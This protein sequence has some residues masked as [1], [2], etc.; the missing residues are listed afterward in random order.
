[1]TYLLDAIEDLPLIREK[2]LQLALDVNQFIYDE[3]SAVV[4]AQRYFRFI[5]VYFSDEWRFHPID[6]IHS[7]ARGYLPTRTEH[8]VNFLTAKIGVQFLQ[9]FFL[10]PH[11]CGLLNLK[12][13]E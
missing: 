9:Q 3:W 5:V 8:N 1:M 12:A 4:I 6:Y 10:Q 2:R 7:E 13:F 11:K